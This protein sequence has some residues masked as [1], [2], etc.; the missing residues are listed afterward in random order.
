ML[1]ACTGECAQPLRWLHDKMLVHICGLQSLGAETTH[2]SKVL[3]ILES[4]QR[5][6]RRKLGNQSSDENYSQ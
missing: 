4:G 1:P 6:S 5:E 3:G 2:Y